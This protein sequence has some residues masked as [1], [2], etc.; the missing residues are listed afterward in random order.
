[1]F[2]RNTLDTIKRMLDG[3]TDRIV[4]ILNS[5]SANQYS[6]KDW[7]IEKLNEYP[8]HYRYKTLDKKIDITLLASWYGLLA[9]R[10]IDKFQLKKIGHIDCIDFDPAAKSVAK[11]LWK[12]IDAD[13]L[14]NGK[15]T[16]VKF[17]EQDINTIDNIQ[18]PIVICTSCEHLDQATI[19]NTISRL[20]E[21]TLVVL[22]S[23]NYKEV[24]EH[25]NT[26]DTVEDFANQYVSKL[27]NMKIYE[28]DFVKY[29]RF[30][31]IGTKI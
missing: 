22:Q 12:K 27:R 23:N 20:E 1:M 13:N 9:Y 18:S 16:Y 19:Y 28:K 14:K 21:H 11:K 17:I 29:K 5:L 15:L 8:H 3:N 7:L 25:V 31:V 2:D 6:S 26:V 24:A 10:L 30:M 4:D